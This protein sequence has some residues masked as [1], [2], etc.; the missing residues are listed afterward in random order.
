MAEPTAITLPGPTAITLPGPMRDH[1]ERLTEPYV[2][3]PDRKEEDGAHSRQA[4]E[5]GLP[6]VRTDDAV[7]VGRNR[8]G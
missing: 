5:S 2:R 1:L 4:G 7:D 3:T 8:F 6:D